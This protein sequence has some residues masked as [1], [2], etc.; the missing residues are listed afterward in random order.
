M[1][2]QYL[3]GVTVLSGFLESSLAES[4]KKHYNYYCTVS[5]GFLVNIMI[6]VTYYFHNHC[7]L[8]Y[9]EEKLS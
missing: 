3:R 9:I 6:L 8:R 1:N 5:N 7:S 4:G 2:E